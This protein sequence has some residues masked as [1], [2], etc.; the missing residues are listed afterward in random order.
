[1]TQESK[2]ASASAQRGLLLAAHRA[3]RT[4]INTR[5]GQLKGDSTAAALQ[6]REDLDNVTARNKEHIALQ[7]W[8]D[9][10]DGL[11]AFGPP[12]S[13]PESNFREYV[14]LKRNALVAAHQQAVEDVNKASLPLL[15]AEPGTQEHR[16]GL[17]VL[18]RSKGAELARKEL[19]ERFDATFYVRMP[20]L[21]GI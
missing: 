20:Q 12:A 14:C 4:H 6:L 1:M 18:A 7:Q 2:A 21:T 11:I 15:L 3:F 17:L 13:V 16:R 19:L 9:L 5:C 8:A 10:K